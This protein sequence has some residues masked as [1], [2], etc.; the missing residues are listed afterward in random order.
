M[1]IP[2]KHI[3]PG[4]YKV[5]SINPFYNMVKYYL[6]NDIII[7]SYVEGEQSEFMT[8]LYEQDEQ[9]YLVITDKDA[10]LK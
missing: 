1:R 6:D 2:T 4:T 10:Y 5:L 9:V 8:K 7:E 3:R